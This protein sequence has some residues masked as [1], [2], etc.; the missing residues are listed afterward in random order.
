[1]FHPLEN[2]V[3]TQITWNKK[4]GLSLLFHVLESFLYIK[5]IHAILVISHPT[6]R[7]WI[8]PLLN[9]VLCNC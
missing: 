7:I 4:G 5:F 8:P 2:E 1:M 9:G 6:V 3:S